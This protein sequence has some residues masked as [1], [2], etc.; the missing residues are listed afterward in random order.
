MV[1]IR[2]DLPRQPLRRYY[3]HI[4]RISN[5][6]RTDMPP[7]APSAGTEGRATGAG[8]GLQPGSDIEYIAHSRMDVA[9]WGAVDR[10]YDEEDLAGFPVQMDCA[11]RGQMAELDHQIRR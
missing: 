1:Q 3:L 4:Q 7:A 5:L 9:L 11:A 6:R 10:V 2:W 8:D